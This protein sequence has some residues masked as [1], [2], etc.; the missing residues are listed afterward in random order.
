M[1]KNNNYYKKYNSRKHLNYLIGGTSVTN[2]SKEEKEERERK[3]K[4]EKIYNLI[5]SYINNLPTN[6]E[7]A[8]EAKN[9][10]NNLIN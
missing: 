4:E 6:F 3:E 5:N 1:K 8:I 2:E 10:I 7:E 9:K